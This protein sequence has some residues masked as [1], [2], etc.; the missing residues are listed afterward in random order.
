[1]AYNELDFLNNTSEPPSSEADDLKKSS[2]YQSSQRLRIENIS[3]QSDVHGGGSNILIKEE[4]QQTESVANQLPES[5]IVKSETVSAENAIPLSNPSL[6]D[7]IQDRLQPIIERGTSQAPDTHIPGKSTRGIDEKLPDIIVRQN[8]FQQETKPIE[9]PTTV[10]QESVTQIKEVAIDAYESPRINIFGD[11][12]VL[13]TEDTSFGLS[14]SYTYSSKVPVNNIEVILRG[15]P[16]DFTLT[17]TILGITT[18]LS[19][20]SDG[21]YVIDINDLPFISVIPPANYSGNTTFQAYIT[22]TTQDGINLVSPSLSITANVQAVA[23][24]PTSTVSNITGIEDDTIGLNNSFTATSPDAI[25]T[26]IYGSEVITTVL[27]GVPPNIKLYYDG[28]PDTFLSQNSSGDWV[29]DPA[30]LSLVRF[31]TPDN[32]KG[33]FTVTMVATATE[34]SN[35]DSKS[36]SQTFDVTINA[37]ADGISGYLNQSLSGNE[38]AV[39]T[40]SSSSHAV[41]LILHDPSE[42]IHVTMS[43]LPS[44]ATVQLYDGSVYNTTSSTGTIDITSWGRIVTESGVTKWVIDQLLVTPKTYSDTDFNLNFAAYTTDS[45][46]N[47]VVI[48]ST[49]NFDVPVTVLAV[50][51][52]AQVNALSN[53]TANTD[54][55]WTINMTE[56]SSGAIF[57][58]FKMA[59]TDMDGSELLNAVLTGIPVGTT[60]EE[61]DSNGTLLATNNGTQTTLTLIN[62]SNNDVYL[63]IIPANNR[64][65]DFNLTLTVQTEE[66]NPDDAQVALRYNTRTIPI[67]VVIAA[68]AD[69]ADIHVAVNNADYSSNFTTS[70]NE[71]IPSEPYTPVTFSF[72]AN[73]TDL[74]DSMDTNAGPETI[75]SI[76]LTVLPSGTVITSSYI[77]GGTYTTITAGDVITFNIPSGQTSISGTYTIT[78]PTNYESTIHAVL[79]VTTTEPTNG[80]SLTTSINQTINIDPIATTPTI[81]AQASYV[82]NEDPAANSPYQSIT[83]NTND[84]TTDDLH[85]TLSG[86]QPGSQIT[87]VANPAISL[88]V[89]ADGSVTMTDQN[90]P[91]LYT[92]TAGNLKNTGTI[93]FRLIPPANYSS[94][95]VETITVTATAIDGTSTAETTTTFDLTVN[96]VADPLNNPGYTASNITESTPYSSGLFS[97]IVLTVP[98]SDTDGSESITSAVLKGI[99]DGYSIEVL[100][101][102]GLWN[103]VPLIAEGGGY[104]SASVLDYGILLGDQIH[105]RVYPTDNAQG[106]VNLSAVITNTD[107]GITTDTN[108]TTIPITF[109]VTQILNDAVATPTSV[110]GN[111]DTYI[112]LDL[113]LTL[114]DPTEYFSQLQISN[115]PTGAG[116]YINNHDGNG[117]VLVTANDLLAAGWTASSS[118]YYLPPPDDNTNITLTV[119]FKL[120]EPFGASGPIESEELSNSISVTV[121]GQA[122]TPTITS[123]SFGYFVNTPTLMGLNFATSD[124]DGSE[125]YE[126]SMTVTSEELASDWGIINGITVETIPPSSTNSLFGIKTYLFSGTFNEISDI[127]NNLK[128]NSESPNGQFT[129]A[130]TTTVTENDY[131]PTNNPG[132]QTEFSNIFT[133]NQLIS[134]NYSEIV[135]LDIN[136]YIT[137]I[138]DSDFVTISGFSS[139]TDFFSV[140]SSGTQSLIGQTDANGSIIL[141]GAQVNGLD[142][143]E[144]FF[145]NLG[146]FN[147]FDMLVEIDNGTTQ[148]LYEFSVDQQTGSITPQAG[149]FALTSIMSDTTTYDI[150]SDST[151]GDHTPCTNQIILIESGYTEPP[152]VM[153]QTSTT[154]DQQHHY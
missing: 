71:N 72:T 13:T 1:M 73:S 143:N 110:T 113:G 42:T 10:K 12:Q 83:F 154:L 33:K 149:D 27:K 88:T 58:S 84:T 91:D 29:V 61:Y 150:H 153:D 135:L 79:S 31:D 14:L 92:G 26:G 139:N 112:Q 120:T 108:T 106:N 131:H 89:G 137:T 15:M 70:I 101:S 94:S 133:A 59:L 32:Y 2:L 4:L 21:S 30:K 107:T 37:V 35:G 18:P 55:S 152:T 98:L 95:A 93:E 9:Q 65:D 117:T 49:T 64:S 78:P 147:T 121:L 6:P 124:T 109:N 96:P 140:D 24:I 141:T 111:E 114:A 119:N 115:V 52:P 45:G 144:L 104:N 39:I 103:N 127:I 43:G 138:S 8:Q 69:P 22:G 86:L 48:S 50:A 146:G 16:N 130:L 105:I 118:L 34:P 46:P 54:G 151:Y 148:I 128:F 125:M 80:D 132:G 77:T 142:G 87:S 40:S 145:D 36:V 56:D 123:D 126:I 81:S 47:G 41:E 76:T 75:T 3:S 17:K 20:Q 122:D 99:P 129:F 74:V 97:T 136:N 90:W 85:V 11:S 51:Q 62:T 116:I 63:K 53:I 5:A 44:G 102:H 38:D 7:S 28:A 60:I 100:S 23:D 134:D 57:Y 19:A 67:A 68:K 25:G 66:T 82:I